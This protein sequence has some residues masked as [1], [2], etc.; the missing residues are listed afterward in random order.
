MVPHNLLVGLSLCP[1]FVRECEVRLIEKM[2]NLTPRSCNRQNTV[3]QGTV[4]IFFVFV[5]I[6]FF[7]FL[8]NILRF[9]GLDVLRIREAA[10]L[11]LQSGFQMTVEKPKPKQL[12]RPL[13]T[14]A[15]SAMNQ[16][17][18]LAITC[19][20]LEAREKSCVHGAIGFDFGFASHWLKNWRD[21]FTPLTKRS[22]RNH[23][24]T[25]DSHLKTALLTQDLMTIPGDAY[26]LTVKE[27]Q[28]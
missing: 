4:F 13:T 16:S 5:F 14:G 22:N 26:C 24:I 2:Q 6:L 17:Q 12:L 23:V 21:S 19:N 1:R 28:L 20:S 9:C 3:L 15:G 18:F 27:K 7:C 25:F 11:L 8:Q 10:I